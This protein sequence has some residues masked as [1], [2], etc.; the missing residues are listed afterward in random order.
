LGGLPAWNLHIVKTVG[1]ESN[2]A[3]SK[4]STTIGDETLSYGWSNLWTN[5]FNSTAIFSLTTGLPTFSG[6]QNW[7]QDDKI[8]YGSGDP[9]YTK[10]GGDTTQNADG[11]WSG[12]YHLVSNI[13]GRKPM[14][15]SPTTH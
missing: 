14:A 8:D 11:T 6:S 15:L 2:K 9:G 12:E 7:V 5:A 13:S 10:G 3:S 4:G 1:S